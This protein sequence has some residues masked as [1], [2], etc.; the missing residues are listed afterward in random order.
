MQRFFLALVFLT[1]TGIFIG[2]DVGQE[3]DA[4]S[5]RV[6]PAVD[7]PPVPSLELPTVKSVNEDGSYTVE[8]LLHN[9]AENLGKGVRVSGIVVE[10]HTCTTAQAGTLCPPPYLILVDSLENPSAQ[11]MVVGQEENFSASEEGEPEI[12]SGR[13]QQWSADK[14]YVRSEGLV[15]VP[16]PVEGDG[17]D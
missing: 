2:C 16:P 13:F 17:V 10:K 3:N 6:R 4:S 9:G 11:L 15:E 8:G 7:L 5:K 12:I 1:Y 14:F